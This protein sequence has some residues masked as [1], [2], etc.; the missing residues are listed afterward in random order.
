MD[1]QN[2]TPVR[3]P[4]SVGWVLLT[5]SSCAH[6]FAGWVG[7]WELVESFERVGNTKRSGDVLAEPSPRRPAAP[8]FTVGAVTAVANTHD[9]P[10]IATDTKTEE[11]EAQ[12]FARELAAR[13]ERGVTERAF[14]AL[15][16]IAAV[17]LL[18]SLQRSLSIE[19]QRRV[20]AYV[21]GN[22][23]PHSEDAR[24]RLLDHE[25]GSTN[26]AM[27]FNPLDRTLTPSDRPHALRLPRP[28][29]PS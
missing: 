20:K 12:R 1:L 15:V 19:V 8:R 22:F 14:G 9:E 16:I 7:A 10:R 17:E 25:L 21:A 23:V 11:F 24:K 3:Y 18:V 2:E 27:S 26:T 28:H 13:L 6:L 29:D 4:P 5:N